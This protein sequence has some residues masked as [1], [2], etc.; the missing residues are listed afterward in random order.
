[1]TEFRWKGLPLV[2]KGTRAP[3]CRF[4]QGY[5]D[6]SGGSRAC[7]STTASRNAGNMP[8]NP[9]WKRERF[10]VTYE[11]LWIRILFAGKS[12]FP[13]DSVTKGLQRSMSDLSYDSP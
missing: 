5:F 3:S 12:L 11:R 6:F 9:A 8:F 2:T 10:L 4:S 7:I 13:V 1:M